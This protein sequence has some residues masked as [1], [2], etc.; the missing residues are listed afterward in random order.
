M[1]KFFIGAG[2][3][4][5]LLASCGSTESTPAPT[6]TKTV[7]QEAP[8]VSD[9]D[10]MVD[11]IRVKDSWFYDVEDYTIIETA[12]LMCSAL[13]DGAS[14]EDIATIAIDNIGQEHAVALM[15]GALVYICPDQK[16]KVSS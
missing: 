10:L 12:N 6:V 3:I 13:R 2:I 15:A 16:Y 14:M 9:E 4:V 11:M 7:V 1:K 5:F 8:Q